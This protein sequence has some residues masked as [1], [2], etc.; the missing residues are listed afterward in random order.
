KTGRIVAGPDLL[1]RGLVSGDGTSEH[2]RRAKEE[3]TRRLSALGGPLLAND[4]RVEEEI[5]RAIRRYFSDELRKRPLGIPYVT[6]VSPPSL[7][8]RKC[9][10]RR[11]LHR[12][13]SRGIRS[14]RF[15][16]S[17]PHLAAAV[18]LASYSR[19]R[20]LRLRRSAR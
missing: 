5:V 11:W 3:L 17:K 8:R 15:S 7:A 2:M 18:S 14:R 19:S 16:F 4:P 20:C 12:L 1:S 10:S 9:P 13:A 6:R